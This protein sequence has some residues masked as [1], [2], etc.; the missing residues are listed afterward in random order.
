MPSGLT[1]GLGRYF[2]LRFGFMLECLFNNIGVAMNLPTVMYHGHIAVGHPHVLQNG[3][4]HGGY[5][6]HEDHAFG[7]M[8][9]RTQRPLEFDT[10]SDAIANMQ[11][12]ALAWIDK[13]LENKA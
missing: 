8:V 11:T 9:Y 6:I 10:P 2:L 1:Q 4:Y 12:T 13:H 5:S 7:R 3:K